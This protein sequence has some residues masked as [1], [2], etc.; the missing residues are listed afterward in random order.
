MMWYK[1]PFYNHVIIP[2][3]FLKLIQLNFF[4]GDLTLI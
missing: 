2:D 4:G 1:I 3:T